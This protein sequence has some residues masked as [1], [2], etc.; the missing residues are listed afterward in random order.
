M[1]RERMSRPIWSVPKKCAA[2]GPLRLAVGAIAF[3][4]YGAMSGAV[5][6]ISARSARITRPAI[7]PRLRTS[8]RTASRHRLVA[9]TRDARAV[10]GCRLRLSRGHQNPSRL[11]RRDRRD[12]GRARAAENT[13][14]SAWTQEGSLTSLFFLLSP[15]SP[16]P[17]ERS[18]SCG[19]NGPLSHSGSA[20]RAPN[21]GGPRRD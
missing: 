11:N 10:A 9:R 20:D 17:S 1:I 12:A 15:S 21:R 7:A 16:R 14:K 8:R 6:A 13:R 2:D 4:S 5:I 18:A 19:S 3:G